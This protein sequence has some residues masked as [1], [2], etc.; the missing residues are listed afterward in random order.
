MKLF[1]CFILY[2][3]GMIPAFFNLDYPKNYS[4]GLYT[5]FCARWFRASDVC[6][7]QEPLQAS[8]SFH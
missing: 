5:R 4:S 3:F 7:S 2:P 1:N 8:L 6:Q